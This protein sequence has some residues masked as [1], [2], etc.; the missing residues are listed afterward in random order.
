MALCASN[1]QSDSTL[2]HS[3]LSKLSFLFLTGSPQMPIKGS[4]L[5]LNITMLFSKN[6]C[7]DF[8]YLAGLVVHICML[9]YYVM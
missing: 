6:Q 2:Q 5:G 9:D 8:L 1:H 4:K 3:V 7:L